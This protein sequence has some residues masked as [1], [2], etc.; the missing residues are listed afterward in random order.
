M[1]K[2]LDG[3]DKAKE[4]GFAGYR[5]FL[6]NAH[7]M[8]PMQLRTRMLVW[9]GNVCASPVEAFI[10]AGRWLAACECTGVEY[11]TPD[12]PIFFCHQCGNAAHS[13]SARPVKF[14]DKREK[15]EELLLARRV[16]TQGRTATEQAFNARPM[17][18]G[19]GRDWS[20][21]S[22]VE[23]SKKNREVK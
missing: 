14:P 3:N 21:E 2:I 20:G 16:K 10:N 19:L 13:G 5:D 22:V 4:M 8:F 7:R 1:D 6:Q 15:I 12:D 9:T 17:V 11:V 23:L 18:A